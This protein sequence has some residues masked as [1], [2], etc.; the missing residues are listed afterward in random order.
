MSG[1]CYRLQIDS[2][3]PL[4]SVSVAWAAGLFDGEGS[5]TIQWSSSPRARFGGNHVLRCAVGMTHQGAVD[6]LAFMF[7]G[8]VN[9]CKGRVDSQVSWRWAVSSRLALGFLVLVEPFLVV[10]VEQARLGIRF[11]GERQRQQVTTREEFMRREWFRRSMWM[12][13]GE[14]PRRRNHLGV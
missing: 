4:L 11:M 1:G 6:R 10:K 2:R 13:N 14:Q 3:P 12:L 9:P 5:V 7:G 8:R